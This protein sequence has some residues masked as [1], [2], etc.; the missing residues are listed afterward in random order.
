MCREEGGYL[1]DAHPIAEVITL[2]SEYIDLRPI[3]VNNYT[4]ILK[5]YERYLKENNILKPRRKDVMYF[6]DS[7]WTQG[8]SPTTVQKYMVVIKQFYKWAKKHR[9][10]FELDPAYKIDIADGIK[11]AKVEFYYKKE[12]L[13]IEQVHT[14]LQTANDLRTDIYGYRNYAIILLMLVTGL[15]TMEITDAKISDISRI[16]KKTILY[17]KGKGSYEKHHFVRLPEEVVNAISDYLYYRTDKS[18]Y[19]FVSHQKGV[20]SLGRDF[21]GKM[22]K[23]LLLKAGIHSKRITPHSLRHTTAYLNLKHGGTLTAT[24][25]LLRHKHIT[26]TMIY[27]DHLDRL[28]NDSEER[29]EHI[30]F[31]KEE[32]TNE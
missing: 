27:A 20:H 26:S 17:I 16:D 1:L 30:Y 32:Q 22:V 8:K 25:Q 6:R 18:P 7:L 23:S 29:L 11:G 3:T 24:R 13:A 12:P 4:G 9:A 28:N 19:L 15:R 10:E 5:Q 31:N 14:L 2:F 21:I